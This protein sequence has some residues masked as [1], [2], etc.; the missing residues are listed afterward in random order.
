MS[1]LLVLCSCPDPASADAIAVSVVE[2]RLAACVS[3]LPGMRSVYRWEGAIH[4][5]DEVLLLIKTTN[6]QFD[7]LKVQLV[8]SHPSA[9]PEILA[10]EAS[11]G[12]D[13]YLDWVHAE[14]TL[15]PGTAE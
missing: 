8:M 7:A 4:H 13:R 6:L 1:V 11:A 9:L 15:T 10:F 5:D 14:T 2:S 3:V 12:L